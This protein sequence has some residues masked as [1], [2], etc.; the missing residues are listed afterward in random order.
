MAIAV[1][2]V[3][4]ERTGQPGL[5]RVGVWLAIL[6]AL[7]SSSLPSPLYVTYQIQWGLTSFWVTLLFAV[8]AVGVMGGLMLMVRIGDRLEDRRSAI[9]AATS[10]TASSAL[11]PY[12]FTARK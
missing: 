5:T 8:Y 3:S 10:L 9:V 4:E 1:T 7:M 6:A 11:Y 12:F 2:G